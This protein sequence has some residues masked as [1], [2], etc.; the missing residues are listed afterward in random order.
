MDP[1]PHAVEAPERGE[2]Q[3]AQL[4]PAGNGASPITD[5]L[6]LPHEQIARFSRLCELFTTPRRTEI[7]HVLSLRPS[8]PSELNTLGLKLS[9]SG[10]SQHLGTLKE[11]DLVLPERNAQSI[12]YRINPEIVREFRDLVDELLPEQIGA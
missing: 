1:N 7:F 2:V 11:A 10:I 12:T 6:P 5:V 8:T 4:E 9:F 3:P